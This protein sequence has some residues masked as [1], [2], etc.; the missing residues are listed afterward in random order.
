MKMNSEDKH[1]R[2]KRYS[3][4]RPQR[5]S[6]E[7]LIP[8]RRGHWD[9]PG[10]GCFC[11]FHAKKMSGWSGSKALRTA[12][13]LSHPWV[14]VFFF[15]FLQSHFLE[16]HCAWKFCSS[17]QFAFLRLFWEE[18]TGPMYQCQGGAGVTSN[19]RQETQRVSPE[20]FSLRRILLALV[21]RT[22]NWRS[23]S[24]ATAW[25]QGRVCVTAA[26][27]AVGTD[28]VFVQNVTTNVTVYYYRN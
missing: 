13:S 2:L 21:D 16:S 18:E 17:W 10:R 14:T 20:L 11:K 6:D 23:P 25:I 27:S 15:A 12:Q 22:T 28:R 8:R 5:P 3:N 4:P 9:R 1:P 26:C 24:T 7:D 19:E